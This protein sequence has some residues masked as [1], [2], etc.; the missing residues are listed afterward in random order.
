MEVFGRVK[1]CL[2]GV[3]WDMG[4]ADRVTG[5]I[6]EIVAR[7]RELQKAMESQDETAEVPDGLAAE[8]YALQCEGFLEAVR[9]WDGM[10][11]D[12]KPVP[13]SLDAAVD[14]LSDVKIAVFNAAQARRNALQG[15]VTGPEE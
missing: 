3:T 2:Y 10:E 12:G 8:L 1:V 13:F 7:S 5:R 9:G 4:V 6:T 15:N 14:V 11:S